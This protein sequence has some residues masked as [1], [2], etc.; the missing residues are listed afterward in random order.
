MTVAVAGN[1]VRPDVE[2][3]LHEF[4]DVFEE[5]QSLPPQREV[6]PQNTPLAREWSNASAALSISLYPK[7]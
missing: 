5:P 6:D 1:D 2:S 4:E 7:E 3:I